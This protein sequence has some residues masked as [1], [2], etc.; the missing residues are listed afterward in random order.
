MKSE[1]HSILKQ[2]VA[3]HRDVI[4]TSRE[5]CLGILLDFG[6]IDHP[7][8]FSL[9][10]AILEQIP[11][12]LMA[13]LPLNGKIIAEIASALSVKKGYQLD[14]AVFVVKCWADSLFLYDLNDSLS[15][16][17]STENELTNLEWYYLEG[18][19]Q[20]GPVCKNTVFDLIH[21]G[22]IKSSTL[23]WRRGMLTWEYASKVFDNRFGSSVAP[24]KSKIYK[25]G[26]PHCASPINIDLNCIASIFW[27]NGM[28]LVGLALNFWDAVLHSPPS[29]GAG[30][31]KIHCPRCAQRILAECSVIGTRVECPGCET[32]FIFGQNVLAKMEIFLQK[33]AARLRYCIK[34]V[35]HFWSN[36]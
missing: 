19:L 11:E 28:K 25:M 16:D 1:A 20:L 22:G 17:D 10:D 5:I 9:A 6:G 34:R 12:Q 18:E 35:K 27:R 31:C 32:T 21:S 14:D 29:S 13:S 23:L 26:C 8:V 36:H 24:H 4:L 3:E 2:A 33:L 30:G 7:E 15:S